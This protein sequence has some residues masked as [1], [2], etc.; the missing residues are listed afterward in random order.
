MLIG[1]LWENILIKFKF[2][3]NILFW[4]YS[5]FE[6]NILLLNIFNLVQ[7]VYPTVYLTYLSTKIQMDKSPDK[8]DGIGVN[9]MIVLL[10]RRQKAGGQYGLD[11]RVFLLTRRCHMSNSTVIGTALPCDY[12]ILLNLNRKPVPHKIF[13]VIQFY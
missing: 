2:F 6:C 11:W 5:C 1:W 3:S 8:I 4:Q 10:Q 9:V 7:S 13:G 12:D